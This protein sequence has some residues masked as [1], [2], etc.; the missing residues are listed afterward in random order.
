MAGA[1]DFV[2]QG[3]NIARQIGEYARSIT[4]TNPA[5]TSTVSPYFTGVNSLGTTGT[6]IL[7]TA[8]TSRHGILFHNPGTTSVYIF[9]SSIATVPTTSSIGGTVVIYGG[10]TFQMP[11][12]QF[13][14]V[15]DGWSG[16][17]LTGSSQPLTIVEFF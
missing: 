16:F 11:A 8:S 13:P 17:T 7:V 9:P 15:T 1:D 3:Q 5:P 4:N 10:G 14:N 12:L 6:T 2:N